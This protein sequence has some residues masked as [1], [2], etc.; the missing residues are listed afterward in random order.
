VHHPAPASWGADTLVPVLVNGA[1]VQ[2]PLAE[3]QRGYIRMQDYTAKTQQAAGQ[4]RQAQ[5]AHQAFEHARATLEARLPQIIGGMDAE[6]AQPIDWVK[7]ARED[8]IGYA[9]KDAR[10]KQYLAAKE[11]AANLAT[12]RERENTARKVEMHRLGHEFLAATLPGWADPTTRQQL[13]TLQV[14]HLQSVGY[15]PEEIRSY[16]ALDPRQIVILEESRRFRALVAA[17]PELLR[18]ADMTPENPQARGVTPR[19]LGGN[20]LLASRDVS[21]S[22]ETAAQA[23]WDEVRGGSG[24]EARERAVALIAARR[25]RPP[26]H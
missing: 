9:Q 4:L 1:Q 14:Q 5:E 18:T 16:E 25:A 6:F 17:H 3:L 7:L 15:S 13:Q 21:L 10:H 11:E 19:A 26:R 2:V 23:D 20:G 24:A 8:P 22:Q 12:L